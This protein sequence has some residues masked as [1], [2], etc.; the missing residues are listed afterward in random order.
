MRVDG[1]IVPLDQ[2]PMRPPS[3]ARPHRARR[4]PR[5]LSWTSSS[6]NAR[7]TSRSIGTGRPVPGERVH[8][9]GDAG[10]LAPPDPDKIPTFDELGLPPP[11]STC[12]PAAGLVL[13]TGPTGPGIHD[14]GDDDRRGQRERPATSSPSK[15]RSS[16]CTGTSGR[17][18]AS[19]RSAST[20]SVVRSGVVPRSAKTPTS[21]SSARCVTRRRSQSADDRRDRPPGVRHC[22]PTTPPRPSTASST[23]SRP[24]QPRSGPPG[25]LLPAIVSQ[26]LLPYRGRPSRGLR[27]P[28]RQQHGEEHRPRRADRSAAE[29]DRDQRSR[30]HAHASRRRSPS[31]SPKGW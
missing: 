24:R 29:P 12:R 5:R 15:T 6:W 23:C 3:T 9:T 27:G 28:D 30:R 2:A 13:V 19:A 22:T 14:S 4:P 16:T 18:S 25:R 21:S 7:S 20:P 26:R 17:R 1:V 31:W 10:A 8:P 11:S